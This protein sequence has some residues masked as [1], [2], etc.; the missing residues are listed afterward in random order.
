MKKNILHLSAILFALC[1]L[2]CNNVAPV[3]TPEQDT[4]AAGDP[5]ELADDLKDSQAR[6]LAL[7]EAF[8]KEYTGIILTYDEERYGELDGIR[9]KYCGR[10]LINRF[11]KL[12]PIFD[13]FLA[14]AD[15]FPG[16]ENYKIAPYDDCIG[17]Y[18]MSYKGYEGVTE[19]NVEV[20]EIEGEL[21][22]TTIGG[23]TD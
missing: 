3:E 1:V 8:Y 10:E 23:W 15:V 4:P 11:D 22:I 19:V 2:S 14:A 20:K 13:P 6:G 7:V 21:K 17:W 9:R 5:K 16:L 18:T 12:K